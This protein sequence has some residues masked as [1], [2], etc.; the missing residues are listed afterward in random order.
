MRLKVMTYN[1]LYGFHERDGTTLRY[2]ARRAQAAQLVVCAEAPDILALTEAV[3]C[4]AGGRFIRHDFETMF[5]LPH[6]HGVGFE[7]EWGNVIASRFPIVEV[8]RVPLGGSP[9]GISPSGL[10]ATLDCD[11]RTV[12]VD[13]VHPSPHIT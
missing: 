10:R 11:G 7:G 4:G 8:E 9:S 12:H 3:Y 5:G 13:I 1:A 6:V 2:Q